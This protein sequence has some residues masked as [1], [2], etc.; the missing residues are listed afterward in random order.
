LE[1]ICT[2]GHGVLP[3]VNTRTGISAVSTAAR[4]S[5]RF[6]AVR[7][8]RAGAWNAF[9][10][11]LQCRLEQRFGGEAPAHW[12]SSRTSAIASRLMP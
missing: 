5:T 12:L 3:V 1:S 4:R 6:V 7:E 11:Q 8:R 2:L 9:V 10:Q